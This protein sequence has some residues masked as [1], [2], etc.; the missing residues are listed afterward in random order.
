V[1]GRLFVGEKEGWGE[2]VCVCCVN[3]PPH[4][5]RPELSLLACDAVSGLQGRGGEGLREGGEG[6]STTPRPFFISF[7]L[8]THTYRLLVSA[9]DFCEVDVLIRGGG[10]RGRGRA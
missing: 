4:T 10:G 5:C 8:S 3:L 6:D 9:N 1:R 2:S 7:L